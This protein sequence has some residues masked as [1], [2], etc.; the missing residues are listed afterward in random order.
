MDDGT[1]VNMMKTPKKSYFSQKKILG[2]LIHKFSSMH[3]TLTL[4]RTLPY[5]AERVF[6]K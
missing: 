3:N 1:Y 2:Y 5:S 6:S 4:S